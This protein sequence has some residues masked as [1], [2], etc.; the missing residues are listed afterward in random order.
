MV[1]LVAMK[2]MFRSLAGRDFRLY[3]FGQVISLVGTWVQQVALSWIAYRV[4]GSAFMLG[5]IAFSGQIPMLLVTPL[6]GMLADR[7]SRRDLLL[8]TQFVEMS[9]AGMLAVLAF[10]DG[11]TPWVLIAAS[12]VLGLAGAMEMPAR[13]AFITEI[14]HDR[15]HMS[16]AIAL[17]SLTI[18]VARMAGPAV[19]GVILAA[20]SDTVCFATN[21]ASYLAAIYTLMAIH[22]RKRPPRSGRGSL[23]EGVTYLRQFAPAGW[24]VISVAVAS[25]CVSPFMTF[26]PVYA[27]DIFHGGPDMLG[28]LMGASGFGAL[29]A[30][31]YLARRKSVS[32]L[33]DYI[34]GGCFLSGI[35][36]AT[37]AYN[38]LLTLA[39][40]LLVA[41][42]FSL[43]IIVTSCNI[44]L[45]SMVPEHL[46]G[47]VMALYTMSFIG[48]LPVG[49]LVMGT[50]AHKAGVQPAFLLAGAAAMGMGYLLKR[51]LPQL[52][53]EAHPIL[54][55]KGLLS[56]RT[57]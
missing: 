40:P 7:F 12:V 10:Y 23:L 14:L 32:G 4:T 47:R 27:K 31:L 24:L 18:N 21:A 3:F 15:S 41:S 49:S 42:G 39:L 19:A 25:F 28:T 37:F 52:R 53:V 51:K 44:L 38:Q 22:P 43:I 45:Q 20:F 48:M 5:L 46:R 9:V 29:L 11:F 50:L 8:V 55:E 34:A 1:R 13:Q 6:G 54:S 2:N 56:D 16:N 35:A 26:M 57:D 36:S 30:A 17:N 33:G